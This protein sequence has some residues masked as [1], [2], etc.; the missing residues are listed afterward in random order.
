M[1]NLKNIK[2]SNKKKIVKVL[3]EL[4]RKNAKKKEEYLENF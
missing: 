1:L 4:K 3:R 2:I